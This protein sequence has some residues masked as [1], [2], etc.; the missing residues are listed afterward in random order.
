MLGM[1]FTAIPSEWRMIIQEAVDEFMRAHSGVSLRDT[2]TFDGGG[3]RIETVRGTPPL[4]LRHFVDI[5][6]YPI[7]SM[8]GMYVL[9]FIPDILVEREGNTFSAAPQVRELWKQFSNYP[10]TAGPGDLG[11]KGMCDDIR[12]RIGYR[13]Y[14][15]WSKALSL[16]SQEAKELLF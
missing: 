10:L 13:I 16:S 8:P 3:W 11:N 15:A 14:S 4:V 5:A 7:H 9:R 1:D 12:G 2:G 6:A